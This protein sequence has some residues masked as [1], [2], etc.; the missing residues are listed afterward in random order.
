MHICCALVQILR[1]DA[2][3]LLSPAHIHPSS[4]LSFI[5]VLQINHMMLLLHHDIH[6]VAYKL[7]KEQA[8]ALT[9][10]ILYL[11]NILDSSRHYIVTEFRLLLCK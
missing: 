4:L 7:T 3:S 6:E 8:T 2:H 10:I 9:R 11:R 1:Y 5:L